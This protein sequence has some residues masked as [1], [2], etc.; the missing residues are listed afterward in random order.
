ML[1]PALESQLIV[2]TDPPEPFKLPSVE[3][4]NKASRPDPN[5]P[6]VSKVLSPAA[7]YSITAVETGVRRVL[8]EVLDLALDR[9]EPQTPFVDLGMDSM[10]AARFS[11]VLSTKAGIQLSPTLAFDYPNVAILARHLVEI[12]A[13]RQ[14]ESWLNASSVGYAGAAGNAD[15]NSPRPGDVLPTGGLRLHSGRRMCS[16]RL[17][18]SRWHFSFALKAVS[19]SRSR[20]WSATPAEREELEIHFQSPIMSVSAVD[21]SDLASEGSDIAIIGLAARLPGAES[22]EELWNNLVVGKDAVT[23]VP[24]DRWSIDEYYRP[25]E[26]QPHC[27]NSKWGGFLKS[28][29][30]F[31]APLFGISSREA[32]YMDP[33]HRLL[34]EVCWEALEHAGYSGSALAGQPVGVF[35]GTSGSKYVYRFIG[36]A[37]LVDRYLGSGN[38]L[39]MAANRL[40]YQFNF[41]GPSIAIDTACSSSLVAL[42]LA[43]ESLNRAECNLAV[44]AGVS[45][46][47][48]PEMYVN[49]SQA[50]ML[51]IDG[52]CKTFD[53][54][55]DGYVRSEGAAVVI[56]KKLRSAVADGD[57]IHAVIK[58]TA[59]NHDGRSNGLTAPNG[60][61]Q[62]ALLEK[63]YGAGQINA[64]TISYIEA[65]GTGTQLGD[66]IEIESLS[67]IFGKSSPG[68]RIGIGTVK[69]QIGHLEPAAGIAGLIKVVLAL[70][71]G[72]LPPLIGLENPNR[73]LQFEATPFFVVD[74]LTEWYVP[75]GRKRRAGVSS[76][77]F[78][79]TNAHLVLEEAP[80]QPAASASR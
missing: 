80:Q 33:Q 26:P 48:S 4:T 3:S 31:D 1:S 12:L 76:F 9:C 61:S 22:L 28:I 45:L 6:R 57:T 5:R 20:R 59:I 39:S 7:S 15:R 56:L 75:E 10:L 25:G 46:L 24:D 67:K 38:A 8:S 49:C 42:H 58:A 29:D 36:H 13:P 2:A 53:D 23:E 19:K 50:R 66:T 14:V 32:Q 72:Q 71:H 11:K 21:G 63:I 55:A 35:V 54:R 79:G 73:R 18:A 16:P 70:G 17:E 44:V 43:R 47:L 64:A 52:H 69:T 40:S 41:K 60:P 65:H 37:D 34:L 30:Q 78:G 74:R 68:Q 77:G 62:I 51:A 27:T